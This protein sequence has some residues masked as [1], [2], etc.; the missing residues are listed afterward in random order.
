MIGSLE[1]IILSGLHEKAIKEEMNLN[2][3]DEFIKLI[4]K[5]DAVVSQATG[6]ITRMVESAGCGCGK[7][8]APLAQE[9]LDKAHGKGTMEVVHNSENIYGDTPVAPKDI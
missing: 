8:K 5:T 4:A 6:V 3:F 9:A 7:K 1:R 2:N